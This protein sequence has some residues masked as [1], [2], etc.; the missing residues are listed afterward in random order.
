[1]A[2]AVERLLDLK[3]ASLRDER[4]SQEQATRSREYLNSKRGI[5]DFNI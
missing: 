5:F 1:M 2:R 4:T 3:L